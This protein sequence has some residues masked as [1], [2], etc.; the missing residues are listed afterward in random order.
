MDIF[1]TYA[2]F[3]GNY[4][5]WYPPTFCNNFVTLTSFTDNPMPQN[6]HSDTQ[7]QIETPLPLKSVK[8]EDGSSSVGQI[9]YERSR[10]SK[11]NKSRKKPCKK[12]SPKQTQ[13][14]RENGS[15]RYPQE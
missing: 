13:N 3:T 10:V 5:G 15:G 12:Q 4:Y 11:I 2:F 6:C 1:P 14:H 7:Q 9:T 8:L